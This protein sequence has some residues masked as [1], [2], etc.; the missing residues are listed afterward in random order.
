VQGSAPDVE[1]DLAEQQRV[2]DAFLAAAREGDFE[3]LVAVLDPGVVF[4][5]DAGLDD[6]RARDPIVGA[7]AVAR[8]VLSRGTPLAPLARPVL[9]NGAAGAMV[10]SA[11]RPFAVVGFTVTHGRI[12][13]IDLVLD[14]EKLAHL[15]IG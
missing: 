2:V 3:G 14:Q 4:R 9:V 6:R 11:E 10:G 8:Q 13:A 5:M 12:A 1:P 7:E 15:A